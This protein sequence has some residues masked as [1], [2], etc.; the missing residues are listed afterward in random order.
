[1]YTL[2]VDILTTT[3]APALARPSGFYD[4]YYFYKD[5]ATVGFAAE[6]AIPADGVLRFLGTSESATNFRLTPNKSTL[7]KGDTVTVLVQAESPSTAF[8]SVLALAIDVP[9]T[10]YTVIDQGSGAPFIGESSNFTGSSI[11]IN[12]MTDAGGYWQ[13]DYVEID[14][15][16]DESLNGAGPVTVASFQVIVGSSGSGTEFIDNE[17]VFVN[18]AT[19]TT[20]TVDLNGNPEVVTLADPA[21]NFML[22]PPGTMDGQVE[23][24]ILNDEGQSVDV[25][26]MPRGS[27][28]PISDADF[29]AANGGANSDGSISVTLGID[30]A[31]EVTSIPTG[32]YDVIMHKAYHLD[33]L[34]TDVEIRP[35]TTTT[36]DFQASNMLLAGDIAGWDHDT[37]ASTDSQPDNQ[38][39]TDDVTAV[40]DAFGSVPGGATW[41]AAADFNADNYVYISDYNVVTTNSVTNGEGLLFKGTYDANRNVQAELLAMDQS[42]DEVTYAVQLVNLSSLHAYAV[43]MEINSKHW[44]LL[45]YADGMADF[46]RAADFYKLGDFDATFASGII[47]RDAISAKEMTLVTMTL[48]AK[49]SD[50]EEISI[51]SVSLVDGNGRLS[52]AIMGSASALPAEFALSQNYPNPFNPTT[53]ISFSLPF[54]GQVKLAVYN[55]LGQEITTLASGLM[56][57]GMYKAVWN[58]LDNSGRSVSTGMYFYRLM[59]D[60]RVVDT[61]KMLF[62]K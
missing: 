16:P 41:N 35:V 53:N 19:R 14:G 38:V 27:Y 10:Y 1:T 54:E 23:L 12:S 44:E 4:V 11:P 55:L 37:D 51:S 28:T 7:S 9:S 31:Y 49:V 24:E 52:E 47:G 50:P 20:G 13:L 32:D 21:A 57:A 42:G 18:T 36:V 61:K 8:V 56:D 30:G 39:N 48:K 2:D 6:I 45:S 62:L 17:I 40:S 34:E 22:A 46:H 25:H 43:E 26:I 29:L 15:S 33:Q 58:G 3:M 5:D 59:V 60:N